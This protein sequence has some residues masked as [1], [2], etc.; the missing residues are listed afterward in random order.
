MRAYVI[1][2]PRSLDRRADITGELKKTELDYV[3]VAAVD[4]RDL[5]LSD[6]AVVDSSLPFID[7]SQPI[8]DIGL[9]GGDGRSCIE[10]PEA[11]GR[12]SR[13]SW[14]QH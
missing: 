7:P 2:L 3:I 4:G 11:R 12:Y 10:S 1:N 9:A 6:A 13:M 14:I 5:D 8:V